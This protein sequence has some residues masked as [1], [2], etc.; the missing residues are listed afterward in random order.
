MGRRLT[1]L[2]RQEDGVAIFT[3]IG[4]LAM[5]TIAALAAFWL[6]QQAIAETSRTASV[7]EAFQAANSGVDAALSRIQ[8]NG[9]N[10][11][12]YPISGTLPDG[13]SYVATVTLGD[14]PDYLC[15]STGTSTDGVQQV[16]KVGFFYFSLWNMEI[17]NSTGVSQPSGGALVGNTSVYGPIYCRGSVL[18]SGSSNIDDGPLFVNNGS[19][20][21]TGN[22]SVGAAGAIDVYV[23]G[24]HPVPGA[25]NWTVRTVSSSVPN[26]DLPEVDASFMLASR[27][28][29]ANE[30][31][32]NKQGDSGTA[33]V[34][35]E[36]TGSPVDANTYTTLNPPSDGVSSWYG[37][38]TTRSRQKAPGASACYK[39]ID[40]NA[41]IDASSGLTIDGSASWGSWFGD[42]HTTSLGEHDDFAFDAATGTLY[43]EG[44]VFIDGPLTISVP[45]QYVGNGTLVVNGDIA[46][47]NECHPDTANQQMDAT[48]CLGFVTP[49]N[50]VGALTGGGNVK[51][52]G[53]PPDIAGAFF[54]G[55]TFNIEGH[56]LIKGSVLASTIFWHN[57]AS[58]HLETEPLLPTF[59]PK[60]LPAGDMSIL[61]KGT[62][63]RQ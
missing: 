33:S 44:T 37:S 19:I 8:S 56:P 16:V 58:G 42:G 15:V 10:P 28:N 59:L 43:V 55:G 5:M 17:A 2:V 20:T 39:V 12:N 34:N 29:A 45:V 60:G 35:H 49:T 38:S 4:V 14:S 40:N 1:S 63:S 6:S 24:A 36:A 21:L 47:T 57:G 22:G 13:A 30:S 54:I 26:I 53:E 48:H 62:W 9:F 11:G 3:V 51:G 25:R 61:Y 41:N 31:I 7:N 27:S 50:M 52:Y 32:D 46:V 23:T 18:L